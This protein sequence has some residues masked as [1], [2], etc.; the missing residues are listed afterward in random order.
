MRTFGRGP[1]GPGQRGGFADAARR[2]GWERF[3][4]SS[5][6]TVFRLR[7]RNIFNNLNLDLQSASLARR[8]R[9]FEWTRRPAP[10]RHST[11]NRRIIA[12]MLHF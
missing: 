5:A 11:S 8:F 7:W 9:P 12:G 10:F 1:G 2:T 3:K 4:S 6:L